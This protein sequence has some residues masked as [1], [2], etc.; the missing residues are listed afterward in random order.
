MFMRMHDDIDSSSTY[1]SF[2]AAMKARG[3][4]VTDERHHTVFRVASGRRA[5]EIYVNK[6]SVI[7]IRRG[8]ADI[9]KALGGAR[10]ETVVG[11]GHTGIIRPLQTDARRLLGDKVSG[12][13]TVFVGACGGDASVA[14]MIG[15]FGYV[16]FVTTRSTGHK[17]INNA[18]MEAYIRG[19]LS[20]SP[21]DTLSLAQVLERGA[22]PF[23]RRNA[24]EELREDANL[25]RVNVA[26]VLAARLF[27]AH[28]RRHTEPV[29]QV[30]RQGE[31]AR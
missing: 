20:M 18:I 3:A 21:G 19:L 29:Q 9:A 11:R 23:L 25:Y 27:D 22:A 13:A 5:V 7:G 12:V 4:R 28:V 2:R 1:A 6:P 14:E 30:S 16:P 26:T 31:L 17:V 8:I 10:V 15:T 24:E